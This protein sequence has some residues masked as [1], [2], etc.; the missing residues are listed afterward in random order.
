MC[1]KKKVLM[2]RMYDVHVSMEFIVFLY[3]KLCS[4]VASYPLIFASFSYSTLVHAAEI[5]LK[6]EQCA[7]QCIMS[8]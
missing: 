3:I 2:F 6:L 1:T 4:R 7:S 5:M 8:D